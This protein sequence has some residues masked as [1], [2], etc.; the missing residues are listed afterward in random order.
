MPSGPSPTA[1][2][3]ARRT[4]IAEEV[5]DD[6]GESDAEQLVGLLFVAAEPLKRSD[7]AA[8]LRISPARLAR[9]CA[10]LQSDPTRGLRLE[11]AGDRLGLVSA[12][13]CTASVERYLGKGPPEALSQAALEVLAIVAYE[14]PVTRANIRSIRGVDS[15][16]VVETLMARRL[17]AED[18]RFGGRRPSFLVTTEL[19]LRR[20]GLE[21]LADLPPRQIPE[22][23]A[24]RNAAF[25]SLSLAVISQG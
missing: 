9:A 8:A 18:P 7:I 17:I 13:A 15:D 20:F 21:P 25:A 12:P 16:A 22:T 3:S 6:R 23:S 14:Q 2:I 10:V 4:P 24:A 5:W 19:F 11:D 1:R